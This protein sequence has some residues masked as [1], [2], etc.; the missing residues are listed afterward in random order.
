MR[1]ACRA[2]RDRSLDPSVRGGARALR[3]CPGRCDRDGATP[4]LRLRARAGSRRRRGARRCPRRDGRTRGA[5]EPR[6]RCA[7]RDDPG[8]PASDPRRLAEGDGPCAGDGAGGQ[9]VSPGR[10][11][12]RRAR[13][14]GSR[15]RARQAR[16]APR[17]RR[18]AGRVARAD[19]ARG[20]RRLGRERAAHFPPCCSASCCAR[21]RRSAAPRC[22]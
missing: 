1:R 16:R 7:P 2:Q 22:R 6:A 13:R 19:G 14:R 15:R 5:R 3:S 4:L 20:D 17:L 9:R 12:T 8:I 10:R 11:G 18:H 21:R